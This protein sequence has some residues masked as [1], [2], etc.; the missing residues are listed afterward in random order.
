MKLITHE[1]IVNLNISTTD[2]LNWV[3]DMLLNRNKSYNPTKIHLRPYDGVFCNI[4]PAIVN[5]HDLSRGM[6]LKVVTRFPNREP[7]LDSKLLLV[8]PQTGEYLAL[9]DANWITTMRTGIIAAHSVNL[10]SKKNF[11]KIS[12]MGL[13]NTARATMLGLAELIKDRNIT[14]KLLKYKGQEEL[15]V[16]RFSYLKNFK[17][18]YVD[19]YI[20]AIKDVD[21][22]ISAVTYFKDDI[23]SDEYFD[24]GITLIPIHTRGFTNCDLFFDK[25]FVADIN[26]AKEFKY[27]DNFKYVAETNDVVNGIIPGRENDE[28]RILVYNMG[29]AI[30]DINFGMH[31]YSMLDKSKLLDLDFKLPNEKFYI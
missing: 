14:V 20:D 29:L 9:M 23:C 22:V 19:S 28:E 6:G 25:I 26:P 17:F 24:K 4:M 2:C 21:T 13:G 31:I 1:D 27:F 30:N 3:E 5:K 12:I 7:S 16:K 11:S 18:E 15:F 8:D 10:F